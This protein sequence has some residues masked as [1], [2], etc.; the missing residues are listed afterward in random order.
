MTQNKWKRILLIILI[1]TIVLTAAFFIIREIAY[2]HR[3]VPDGIIAYE[4]DNPHM[5][6][7]K[8]KI[9]A[10]RSGAGI[11]PE[12]TLK[13]FKL[14]VED[15]GFD[16]DYFE[17]DQHITKDNVLIL[18]HD[19]ELDRTSDCEAV[20]GKSNCRP[21]NYTY[22][23]LR[24]LNMGAKFSDENGNQPY[25]SL[26]GRDVPDNL[27][28]LDLDTVLDYLESNAPS[29]YIIEIKNDGELGF[30]ATDILYE[31]LKKRNLLDRVIFGCFNGEITDY[32][33]MVYE[34]R[35]R[36]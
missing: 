19:N 11:A 20:F 25:S 8:T 7:R 3:S 14:C 6:D 27:K 9:S 10:H 28:I 18:L 12:E 16:V 31:T 5:A 2:R 15:I 33:D 35:E 22:E 34:L 13:A 29:N 23:Q 17:F 1:F 36:K 26:S 21:E 4:S 24:Q 30:K 32:P